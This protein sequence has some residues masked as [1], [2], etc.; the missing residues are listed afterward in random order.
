[1]N[2]LFI[3][4]VFSVIACRFSIIFQVLSWLHWI[5]Q[6]VLLSVVL[7]IATLIVNLQ[8]TFS[9]SSNECPSAKI[10]CEHL[11][12]HSYNLYAFQA[13]LPFTGLFWVSAWVSQSSGAC[14]WLHVFWL[15][16]FPL[17]AL[18]GVRYHSCLFKSSPPSLTYHWSTAPS[19]FRLRCVLSRIIA[20]SESG[21]TITVLCS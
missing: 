19:L 4:W 2:Y 18:I 16:A 11:N 15:L 14:S 13:T 3:G 20:C 10:N 1:M 7:V 9:S 8:I 12:L 17:P 5:L 6:S 21:L